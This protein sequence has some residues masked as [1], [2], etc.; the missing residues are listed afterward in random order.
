[1]TL[2]CQLCAIL[3]FAL[4][5]LADD[6]HHQRRFGHRASAVVKRRMRAAAGILVVAAFP[7][8]ILARGW[9][10]GPILWSGALML[11]AGIIFLSL[12]LL[13]KAPSSAHRG[14]G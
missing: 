11:G 5:G 1:M 4:F 9:V 8:A 10:F 3:A 7:A 13:F 12:N 6:A 2:L 14:Q